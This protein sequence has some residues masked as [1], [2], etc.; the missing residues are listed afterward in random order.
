MA[1]IIP[2]RKFINPTTIVDKP[3]YCTMM[4]LHFPGNFISAAV[5]I[6]I[7]HCT[8]DGIRDEIRI[9]C[10]KRY[11][12]IF[13]S[14]QKSNAWPEEEFVRNLCFLVVRLDSV[15]FVAAPKRNKTVWH[16]ARP[17]RIGTEVRWTGYA[18]KSH[19]LIL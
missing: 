17:I 7:G 12:T 5:D 4:L 6:V 8:V 19:I 18:G 14:L 2:V 13:F 10:C 9:T 1:N 16:H 3:V 11:S 15:I